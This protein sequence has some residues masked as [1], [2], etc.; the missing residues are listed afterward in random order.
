MIAPWLWSR[1]LAKLTF[2]TIVSCSTM[3]I[4]PYIFYIEKFI[5]KF[6]TPE[7]NIGHRTMLLHSSHYTVIFRWFLQYS[8]SGPS[9]LNLLWY[10][11]Q[12]WRL[13]STSHQCFPARMECTEHSGS[14]CK[15]TIS[16]R[17]LLNSWTSWQ[18]SW[19][20]KVPGA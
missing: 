9:C 12:R 17:G 1:L 2:L 18:Y 5:T 10:D 19:K 8:A 13:D 20:R 6:E 11:S 3:R 15:Q 16:N 14:K 7:K 4:G